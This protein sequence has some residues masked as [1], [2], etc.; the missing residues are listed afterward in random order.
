ME[1]ALKQANDYLENV[2]ENSPDPIG[3]VNER[4]KFILWNKMAAELYGY[5]FEELHGKSALICMR[6]RLK[7][8]ECWT[9]CA[10]TGP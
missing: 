3:I 2:L 8:K 5:S 4:G 10:R 6:T 9:G 1:Q 7:W